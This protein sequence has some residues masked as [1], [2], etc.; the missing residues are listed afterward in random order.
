M[1]I[2]LRPAPPVTY[3]TSE[4][5]AAGLQHAR[6]LRCGRRRKLVEGHVKF[7]RRSVLHLTASAIALPIMA[8]FAW[9]QPY[10]MRPV[11]IIS[12]FPAGSAADILA[13]LVG[14]PLSQRM[15]EPVLIEDRRVLEAILPPESS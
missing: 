15:A 6:G 12:G 11:R 10:P 4:A 2:E 9:A 8:G 3:V 5:R 13:R 7:D 1:K 14:Q